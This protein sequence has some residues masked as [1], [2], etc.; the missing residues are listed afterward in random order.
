[1]LVYLNKGGMA[2]AY[3]MFNMKLKTKNLK[4]LSYMSPKLF[5]SFLR[6]IYK[7]RRAILTMAKDDFKKQYLG[8][9]LGFFWAI[10][11]PAV[12]IFAIW[13][14]FTFGFRAGSGKGGEIPFVLYLV[15]GFIVW[16]FFSGGLTAGAGSVQSYSYLV[17]KMVF[18]VS[19]LPVVKILSAFYIHLILFLLYLIVFFSKG[20]MFSLYTLQIF[21]YIFATFVL[22]LGL[23]WLTSSLNIFIQDV[24]QVIGVF[25]RI[26]FW[27]TPIFW[28]ID[29]F[30]PK[31]QF[32]LKLNPAYY[33]VNGYREALFYKVWFWER[34]ML[35]LYYW[36]FT[37]FFF[38]LGAIVFKRLRPHFGDVL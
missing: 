4:L 3:F 18:A 15:S 36:S 19:V 26:G 5:L 33:L 6:T 8:S 24:S 25:T 21:Y 35:T 20:Y 1:M 17:K 16:S 28:K 9:L 27:F 37:M 34:P 11:Q 29:K 13:I 12:Y 23:G 31:I 2:V 30:S 22:L 38:I 7:N 14:I 10:A 32:L